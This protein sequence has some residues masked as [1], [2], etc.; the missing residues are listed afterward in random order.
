MASSVVQFNGVTATVVTRTGT[1]FLFVTV[2]AG[3]S[4]GYVTV[5]TGTTTLKSL[6]KFTVHN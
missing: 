4:D 1:T 3:A 5:T 6:R 2:P